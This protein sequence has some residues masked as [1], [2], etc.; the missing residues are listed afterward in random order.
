MSPSTIKSF[1][2]TDPADLVGEVEIADQAAAAAA[3][4]RAVTAQASWKL[5][6]PGRSAAL[7]ALGEAVSA[8][9]DQFT[10]LMVKEVGKPRVEAAGEV[11]RALAILRFYSQVALDPTGEVLPGSTPEAKVVVQ[12]EP[13]GVILAICPWN[14]PLAIPLWKAAPALAYGNTVLLKP[15][16]AAVA[17]AE[18][19]VECADETLPGG[20]L[21]YLPMAGVQVDRL[22][23]DSRIA[24]VTFTG[25]TGVGMGVA[26][27]LAR[28]AA[29]TQAEMG[30]QNPAVVLAD[31]NLEAAADAIVAGAMGYSGQ[32]CTAT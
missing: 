9:A 20:V 4:E 23:D 1:N 16:S 8:R 11:Q 27:R 19:L 28:R 5:D 31:A 13:L 29:P 6:A 25:S 32:K 21:S 24:A 22:L 30:G 12:R 3:L 15:A 7:T 10:E 18:L 14:F 2:P 26:E 17:T